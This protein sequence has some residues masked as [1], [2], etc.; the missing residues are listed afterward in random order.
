[1]IVLWAVLVAAAFAAGIVVGAYTTFRRLPRTLSVMD[2]EQWARLM[3]RVDEED[4]R[5]V[6]S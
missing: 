5:G 3:D 1:M 2:P 4:R 6:D